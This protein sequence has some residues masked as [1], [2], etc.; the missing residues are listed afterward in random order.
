[1]KPTNTPSFAVPNVVTLPVQAA[2]KAPRRVRL[3]FTEPQ[4]G[5]R[6]LSKKDSEELKGMPRLEKSLLNL[7]NGG[8]DGQQTI[9]RLAFEVD[10]GQ[11]QVH[12]GL[13]QQKL[14]GLPDTVLKR[15]AV[16]DH[17]V[18]AIVNTRAN[19]MAVYGRP[20]QDRH[21]FGFVIVPKEGVED[22]LNPD[23]QKKLQDDIK[24]ATKRLA[25]CGRKEGWDA[26][27]QMTFSEYLTISTKNAVVVGKIATE[28]VE[29]FDPESNEYRFHSFR[30]ID[31]GTIFKAKP[32]TTQ[33]E[34]LRAT[35]RLTLERLHNK[36]L[37]A[38]PKGTFDAEKVAWIQVIEGTPRQAFMADECLVHNFYP[39]ADIEY[40]GYPI[41]PLDTVIAAVTT[42]INITTHNKLYFQSGRAARGILVIKSDDMDDLV[43]Q[44][45]RQQFNAAINSVQ[46][47]WR[48]PVLGVGAEED[49]EWHATD[50]ASRDMEF[51]YLSDMTAR[52][53][54]SAF[55]MS[56]EE[57]PGYAHL[58][59]GTNNQALSESNNEYLLL[60]HRDVGLR[61]LV[62]GW[63]DF[64]NNRLFPLIDPE[65]AKKC[66]VQLLGLDAETAEKESIRIQQDMVLHYNY[67]QILNQV[68]K[69]E[70]PASMGGEYPFNPQWQANVDK[71]VMVG[72]Q[73]EYFFG[74]KGAAK[75]PRFQ[76][77][78]DPFFFQWLQYQQQQQQMQM[79]A[80][81]AQQQAA[82]GGGQ[83]P[84]GG[85]GGG[86]GDD[87]SG[88]SGGGGADSGG[89]GGGEGSAVDQENTQAAA[90]AADDLTKA[91]GQAQELLKSEAALPAGQRKALAQHMRIVDRFTHDW[92]KHSQDAV[93]EIMR[94]VK[95]DGDE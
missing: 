88:G 54:L 53:V 63:Q 39:T 26:D 48:V 75:D 61:P 30:P 12:S 72:E 40:Q 32:L 49:I 10:P 9:E 80:Q 78:R 57:L 20:R 82:Q 37:A 52:V 47:S 22:D 79:Q 27:D 41:T 71:F 65:L 59:R 15:I 33:A 58:S 64:I 19:H 45:I 23:D 89:G 55:Q 91:T 38:E 92:V 74:V 35:A 66:E 25:A 51:Q 31:A 34:A 14:R 95:A 90:T 36:T 60:A 56:P 73:M 3:G 1:M 44:D 83:P 43:L 29:A 93:R 7:L 86:G 85:G 76:Y 87:S 68:E 8:P 70:L 69:D 5:P 24:E 11:S 16:Q 2:P 42:H 81:Q 13:W 17:L 77:I 4:S 67:N 62:S 28:V 21:G 84:Q 18:A 94:A 6:L 50:T 46:N